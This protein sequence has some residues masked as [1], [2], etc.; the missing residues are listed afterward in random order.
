MH[1]DNILNPAEAPPAKRQKEIK[2]LDFLEYYAYKLN[3]IYKYKDNIFFFTSADKQLVNAERWKLMRNTCI[4]VLYVSLLF[5]KPDWCFAD[6]QVT[7]DCTHS[8]GG[9]SGRTDFFI[10]FPH[11]LDMYNFEMTSWLL[12]LVLI[13]Y[14]LLL[15][16]LSPRLVMSYCVLFVL[17]VLTG[18]F[19]L[20]GVMRIKVNLL[21][22]FV[23][24]SLYTSVKKQIHAHDLDHFLH[25]PV[26]GA[27]SRGPLLLH[28]RLLGHAAERPLLR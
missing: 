20:N 5:A 13:L 9:E 26:E 10:L 18:F 12:M 4:I 14:D 6:K 7:N 23:F 15:V 25:V 16:E 17:D 28:L 1:D 21:I 8:T 22:R 11:F 27:P 3:E 24:L 19:Y 2:N